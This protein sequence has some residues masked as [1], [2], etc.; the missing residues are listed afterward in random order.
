M[1]TLQTTVKSKRCFVVLAT[2][3][4]LLAATASASAKA[5]PIRS[6]RP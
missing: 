2:A 5:K 6:T 3:I 4:I 1:R